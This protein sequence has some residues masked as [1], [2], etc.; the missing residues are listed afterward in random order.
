MIAGCEQVCIADAL[1]GGVQRGG[2]AA[3]LRSTRAILLSGSATP[4]IR[5]RPSTRIQ[6]RVTCRLSL[7][8]ALFSM[9]AMIA[10]V[11]DGSAERRRSGRWGWR[12]SSAR[13]CVMIFRPSGTLARFY[14]GITR[15]SSQGIR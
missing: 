2:V 14:E 15:A 4:V 13:R 5:R 8:V 7:D 6:N 12:R 1:V 10:F 11:V 9:N 3:D